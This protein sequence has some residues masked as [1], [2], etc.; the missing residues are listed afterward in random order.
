M[1]L[2]STVENQSGEEDDEEVVG[3]PEDFKVTASDHLH[4]RGDDEDEG[5]GDDHPREACDGGEDQVGGDLLRILR[6][7]GRTNDENNDPNESM[8]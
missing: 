8:L 2:P 3:V 4:R 5:E 6:G 1:V 7:G